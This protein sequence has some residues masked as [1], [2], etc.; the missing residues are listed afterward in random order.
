MSPTSPAV[1]TFEP[2]SSQPVCLDTEYENVKM[3]H[4]LVAIVFLDKGKS[5]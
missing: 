1:D 3:C 2:Q 5:C 4:T